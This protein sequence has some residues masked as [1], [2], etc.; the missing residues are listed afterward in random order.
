LKSRVVTI[1][2]FYGFQPCFPWKAGEADDIYSRNITDLLCLCWSQH[3]DFY[4]ATKAE[5]EILVLHANGKHGLLTCCIRP[6][7]IFC[8]G[9]R[10][11]VPS[12]VDAART[13]RSKVFSLILSPSPQTKK[14]KKANRIRPRKFQLGISAKKILIS[15]FSFL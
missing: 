14:E 5:G 15:C 11:L 2:A 12:L 4:S 8:P 7:T 1:C 9:D 13:G 6:G 10:L 3:N